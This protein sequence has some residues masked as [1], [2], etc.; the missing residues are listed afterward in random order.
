[1]DIVL[2]KTLS[3]IEH[4]VITNIPSGLPRGPLKI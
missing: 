2:S 1:M 3:Y 4:Y